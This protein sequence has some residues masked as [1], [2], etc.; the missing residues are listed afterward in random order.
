MRRGQDRT[1]GIDSRS[2]ERSLPRKTKV[3][4]VKNHPALAYAEVTRFVAESAG[5]TSLGALAMRF[6][7]LIAGRTSEALGTFWG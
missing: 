6:L 7:I 5:R 1:D 3:S 4:P 2:R